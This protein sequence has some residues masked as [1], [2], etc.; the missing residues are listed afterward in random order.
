MHESE[1]VPWMLT[2]ADM[3]NICNEFNLTVDGFR[4]DRLSS[5]PEETL[6]GLI[7]DAMRKGIGARKP[8]RG[9]IIIEKFYEQIAEPIIDHQPEWKTLGFDSLVTELDLDYQLRPY[10]KISVI[11]SLQP[12]M[13]IKHKDVMQKNVKEGRE[14]FYGISEISD[15]VFMEWAIKQI[16]D[17][18]KYPGT[19]EYTKFVESI[20]AKDRLE[21]HRASLQI[22]KSERSEFEYL[23][24]LSDTDRL[25]VMVIL[26][27]KYELLR[28]PT[29]FFY[30]QEKEKLTNE[31]FLQMQREAESA[32]EVM[33]LLNRKLEEEQKHVNLVLHDQQKL[34]EQIIESTR[35]IKEL[36]K[37]AC[38]E[39]MRRMESENI[40][41]LF[42]EIVPRTASVIII[43]DHP[44]PRIKKV[45]SRNIFSKK[46][47]LSEKAKG[48]ILNLKS[49]IWFID[50]QT[51]TNTQEW[52][53][54]RNFFI[55]NNF[56]FEEYNDYLDLL[57]QY[58]NLIH[59]DSEET[60]YECD[61]T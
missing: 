25:L 52:I 8:A 42:D 58:I 9:K 35:K 44:D 55:D 54:I 23:L 16:Q 20:G 41:E 36:E 24:G 18:T 37:K 26:Q 48:S 46:Y 56:Y 21:A 38:D 53:Q 7:T 27:E 31:A 13:Y 14:V 50:R 12:Q 29:F 43:S 4:K 33:T 15:G 3:L 34:N 32:N 28:T 2:K 57:R 11:F 49:K 6:R 10:Q 5:R 30:T 51:F 39:S 60:M 22:K 45:F 59:Y 40:K 1:W 19:E 17:D 47:L 61:A